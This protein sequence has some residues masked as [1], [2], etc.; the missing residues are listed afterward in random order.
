M[1]SDF[2]EDTLGPKDLWKFNYH[3][4]RCNGCGAFGSSL[5]ATIQTLNSLPSQNAPD[6]LKRRLREQFAEESNNTKSGS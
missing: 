4:E 6:D 3:L 1:S 5:R 2:L